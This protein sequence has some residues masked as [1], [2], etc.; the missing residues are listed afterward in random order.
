MTECG[1]TG[2]QLISL[3]TG[4]T[5]HRA[6]DPALKEHDLVMDFKKI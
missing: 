3:G 1:D 4:L 2:G 5:Y 6:G